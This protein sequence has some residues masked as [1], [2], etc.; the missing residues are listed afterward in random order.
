MHIGLFFVKNLPVKC[1]FFLNSLLWCSS[2]KIYD[3]TYCFYNYMSMFI[4]NKILI[5]SAGR[6]IVRS[7]WI[8]YKIIYFDLIKVTN[9]RIQYCRPYLW[10]QNACA[11]RSAEWMQ[12]A[13]RR[14]SAGQLVDTMKHYKHHLVK[15][16]WD[17]STESVWVQVTILKIHKIFAQKR[18][19]VSIVCFNYD[20]AV[21]IVVAININ[22]NLLP[23]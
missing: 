1:R 20:Q 11:V 23:T 4:L 19:F 18:E 6:C 2:E 5:T 8:D 14:T 12:T 15:L 9:I 17:N 7:Y 16:Y 13:G 21:F 3:S 10:V 22:Y